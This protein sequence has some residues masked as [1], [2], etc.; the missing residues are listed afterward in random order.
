MSEQRDRGIYLR[1]GEKEP[2]LEHS[3]DDPFTYDG[4]SLKILG[5]PYDLFDEIK[6]DGSAIP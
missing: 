3:P 4:N 2:T 5:G 1:Q 6:L